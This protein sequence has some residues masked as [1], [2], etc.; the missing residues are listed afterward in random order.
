MTHAEST[1][2]HTAA[3]AAMPTAENFSQL[4]PAQIAI[5]NEHRIT[6]EEMGRIAGSVFLADS[7]LVEG[8]AIPTAIAV[9]TCT[10][11]EYRELSIEQARSLDHLEAVILDRNR[12]LVERYKAAA[13]DTPAANDVAAQEPPV[14]AAAPPAAPGDDEDEF[15]ALA[16]AKSLDWQAPPP[17][18]V[19]RKQ[20]PAPQ[21]RRRGE[22]AFY[23]AWKFTGNHAS[24]VPDW[25]PG[26]LIVRSGSSLRCEYT[27]E[28]ESC[29]FVAHIG[30]WVTQMLGES[31]CEVWTD[32]GFRKLFVLEDEWEGSMLYEDEIDKDAY[33]KEAVVDRN[34]EY[35]THAARLRKI[36]AGIEA[37]DGMDNA[38]EEVEWSERVYEDPRSETSYRRRLLTVS[39]T[40]VL[41]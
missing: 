27:V 10:A 16:F 21:Y 19:E 40:I 28:G 41:D 38:L 15:A 32:K 36:A 29:G 26:D 8:S 34:S 18:A 30:D 37:A 22:G 25:V 1:Q 33:P 14:E 7:L 11:D 17:V 6:R 2:S 4:T 3:E 9:G 23:N 35:M 5:L 24:E 12:A 13:Y 20:A 39:V 31:L